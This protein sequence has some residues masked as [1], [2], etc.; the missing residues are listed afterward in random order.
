MGIEQSVV[1]TGDVDHADVPGLLSVADVAV[2]PYPKLPVDFY[3]SPL[4]LF[5]Y[6][7]IGK[8]TVASR[9]GQI[10]EVI[11]DGKTGLLVEPSD[12]VQLAGAI[13]KLLRDESLRQHLGFAA[14]NTVRQNYS[15]DHYI[16]KLL[17]IYEAA[18]ARSRTREN[19]SAG[20]SS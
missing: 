18:L 7:A 9:L 16:G 8:A 2:A 13:V 15:W 5:E 10:A 20:S 19:T 12:P 14:R 3:F 4:K 6:M 11:I 1:L 17:G